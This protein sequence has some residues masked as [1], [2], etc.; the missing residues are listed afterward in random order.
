MAQIAPD[1][2]APA[3]HGPD[4]IEFDIVGGP[5]TQSPEFE[6]G[7]APNMLDNPDTFF[8]S[9][10]GTTTCCGDCPPA[11]RAR[12]EAL[13][14]NY[15]HN[16]GVS[17]SDHFFLRDFGYE[18]GARVS[19]IRHI[20]CLDAWE[21]AYVGPYEWHEFGHFNGVGLTTPL[22]AT[23]PVSISEFVNATQHSQSY[24]TRLNSGEL[25]RR[26]YGWD[27]ISTLAGVRYINID[28]VYRFDSIGQTST[29]ELRVE[30]TNNLFGP[31]VGMELMYPIGH[32]MTSMSVKGALLL[33]AADGSFFLRNN[34]VV[35][36][37]NS[38]DDFELGS[39]IE[40]SYGFSYQLTPAIKLRGGYEFWWIN[41][42]ALVP[43]Q[44]A[45]PLTRSTGRHTDRNE[46]V[47]Y[48]GATA[49][50]EIIW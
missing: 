26:W 27:V 44:I 29:G 48:H 28:E 1:G 4:A 22:N 43:G 34:G 19:L 46:D 49:G 41:G 15:E 23:A 20:D 36:I 14:L 13:S 17:L 25:N 5:P 7:A 30:N 8:F 6:F 32:W 12:V 9:G 50:L 3:D 42:V 45:N 37:D 24:R 16:N 40:L 31:Q 35:E 10:H 11:W 18:N 33:N 38:D 47:V 21:L 2:Q 39:L